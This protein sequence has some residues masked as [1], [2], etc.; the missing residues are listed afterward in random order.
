LLLGGF[1]TA[2][3]TAN[4]AGGGN[5]IFAT[6]TRPGNLFLRL[7]E[8]TGPAVESAGHYLFRYQIV[9]GTGASSGE[10]GSGTLAVTLKPINTNIQGKPVSNP[11]FFGNATLTFE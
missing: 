8:Q 1:Q 11:G 2:G 7:T 5:L 3:F 9:N 10:H 6:K 4:G